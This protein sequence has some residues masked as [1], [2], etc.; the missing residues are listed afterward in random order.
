MDNTDIRYANK[1]TASGKEL[2]YGLTLNNN[3]TLEDLWNSTPAWGYPFIAPNGAP[4]PAAA[5]IIN[6][7]LAQDVAGLGA[8]HHVGPARVF[9]RHP[10]PLRP[11]RRYPAHNRNLLH[12]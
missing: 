6:G 9:C 4:G 2:D 7:L 12:L 11:C 1:T 3:P 10:L 5:P 8:L